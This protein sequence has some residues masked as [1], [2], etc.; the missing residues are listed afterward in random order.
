MRSLSVIV[1]VMPFCLNIFEH[2]SIS[3]QY[4][5]KAGMHWPEKCSTAS[6]Y[7]KGKT[8]SFLARAAMETCGSEEQ[9]IQFYCGMEMRELHF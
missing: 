9:P 6:L 4:C 5:K 8:L 2:Y 1:T 7:S 3:T